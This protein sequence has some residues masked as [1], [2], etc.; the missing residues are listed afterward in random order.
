MLG[1]DGADDNLTLEEF[2]DLVAEYE[3][4]SLCGAA[5]TGTARTTPASL[6]SSSS[7][8]TL[9]HCRSF[10]TSRTRRCRYRERLT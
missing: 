10:T 2:N 1:F 5:Q 8:A 9:W 7:T 6:S 4:Y 3:S